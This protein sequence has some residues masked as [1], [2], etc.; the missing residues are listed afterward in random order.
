[1]GARRS[2][3]A[4]DRKDGGGGESGIDDFENDKRSEVHVV[5]FPSFEAFVVSAHRER[6]QAPRKGKESEGPRTGEGR[7]DEQRA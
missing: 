5:S 3:N 7:A 2:W 6:N 1:M 4:P